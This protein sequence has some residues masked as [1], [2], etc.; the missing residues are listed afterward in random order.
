[1]TLT[2]LE[3]RLYCVNGEL[4]SSCRFDMSMATPSVAIAVPSAD[5]QNGVVAVTGHTDGQFFLWKVSNDQRRDFVVCISPTK[6]HRSELTCLRLCSTQQFSR[7]KD[8][9]A[10]A[11]DDSRCMDLFCGDVDGYVSRWSPQKL[12]QFQNSELMNILN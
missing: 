10:K 8:I 11:F 12:D 1:M 5:W 7:T 3:L 4:V 9:V 2:L 6:V